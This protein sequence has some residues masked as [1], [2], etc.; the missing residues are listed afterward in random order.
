MYAKLL[1]EIL[2][3]LVGEAVGSVQIPDRE[4]KACEVGKGAQRL[5]HVITL[6][7]LGQYLEP[8]GYM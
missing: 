4:T 8:Q 6:T 5:E 3:H 2:N 1:K 7:K